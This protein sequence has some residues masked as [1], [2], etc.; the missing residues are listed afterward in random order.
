MF[1]EKAITTSSPLIETRVVCSSC[2][3]NSGTYSLI[4]EPNKLKESGFS[5]RY[6]TMRN[7]EN[8][9]KGCSS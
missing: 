3:Y 7:I 5:S 4:V 1:F 8:Q 9:G 2:S 6:N